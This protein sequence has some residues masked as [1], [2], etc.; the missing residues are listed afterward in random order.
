M[1]TLI[2]ILIL[3]VIAIATS[4]QKF[5]H[6]NKAEGY[7]A[8]GYFFVFALSVIGLLITAVIVIVKVINNG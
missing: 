6:K 8:L 2:L 1:K 7:D 4:Y 3:L 5:K